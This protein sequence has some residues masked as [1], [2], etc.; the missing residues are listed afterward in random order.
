MEPGDRVVL[1]TDGILE[2]GNLSEEMYGGDRFKRFL[3]INCSAGTNEFSDALL[4]ELSVWSGQ[5]EGQGQKDDIT[6]LAVDFK[7]R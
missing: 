5:P 4:D 6:L 1:Y 2:A 7:T 3:E